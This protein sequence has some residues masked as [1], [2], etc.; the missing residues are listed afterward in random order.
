MVKIFYLKTLGTE[1]SSWTSIPLAEW[2]E[3]EIHSGIIAGSIPAL[4]A[5]VVCVATRVRGDSKLLPSSYESRNPYRYRVRNH[6]KYD[7]G[8]S[9]IPL[10]ERPDADNQGGIV[11]TTEFEV[12]N[13]TTPEAEVRAGD[14]LEGGGLF[15][16]A[17]P[18][19][20]RLFVNSTQGKTLR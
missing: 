17:T 13:A 4:R 5:L 20:S 2:G 19:G 7:F 14:T 15:V 3:A 18:E 12:S 16:S 9:V 1:D 10:H 11:K 6:D 8:T